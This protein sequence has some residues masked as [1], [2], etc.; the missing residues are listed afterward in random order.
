MTPEDK[1][2]ITD[3]IMDAFDEM[4]DEGAAEGNIAEGVV[5]EGESSTE[6]VAEEEPGDEEPED[7]PADEEPEEDEEVEGVEVRAET[8]SAD[9]EPE[10]PEAEEEEGE[11]EVSSEYPPDVQAYLDRHAGNV[12]AALR[13]A[14]EAKTMLD[15]RNTEYGDLLRTNQMLEAQL[16]QAQTFTPTGG[17]DPEQTAWV[18]QAV[19]SETPGA[20]VQSAVAAGEFDLARAVCDAWG[21]EGDAYSA[22]RT[23]QM[24]D[25]AEYHARASYEASQPPPE[26]SRE[27]LYGLIQEQVPDFGEYWDEMTEVVTQLGQ[28]HPMVAAAKSN[29]PNQA[30]LG[31]IDIY[32]VARTRKT[33]VSEARKQH[34]AQ[35]RERG[36]AERKKA[37]VSSASSRTSTEEPPQSVRIAPGLTLEELDAALAAE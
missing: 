18:E 5:T 37:R 17:L 15:R 13:T 19:Q 24:V 6:P 21:S 28:N 11:Q 10:E 25:E 14:L 7:E 32:Q 31:L 16:A 30:A 4:A 3:S 22:L 26:F 20:Y 2:K 34:E 36:V 12:E 8:D 1:D 29:D 9:E 33:R 35:Q 27:E 23:R